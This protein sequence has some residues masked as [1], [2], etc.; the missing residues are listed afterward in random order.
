MS[1]EIVN[2]NQYRKARQKHEKSDQAAENRR[3]HGR[4]KAER[5]ADDKARDKAEAKLEGKHLSEK[6]D[7]DSS[8]TPA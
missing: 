8:G 3:K 6:P 1:A 7:D 2:L 4:T 5:Q